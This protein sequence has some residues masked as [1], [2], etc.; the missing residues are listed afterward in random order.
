MVWLSFEQ[1][2]RLRLSGKATVAALAVMAGASGCYAHG[3]DSEN[4]HGAASAIT[5]ICSADLIKSAEPGV[6]AATICDRFK[7]EVDRALA[8]TTTVGSADGIVP[9]GDW[10]RV[11]VRATSPATVSA[12]V[13]QNMGGEEAILPDMAVDVL[14]RPMG[15]SDFGILA[16]Q[17]A[18]HLAEHAKK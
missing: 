16:T 14:D 3:R 13:V 11:T 10:I 17:V 2:R 15:L 4:A 12:T 9:D 8:V 18:T 7:A 1:R 6:T 5:F